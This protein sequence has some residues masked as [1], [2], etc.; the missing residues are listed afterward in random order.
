MSIKSFFQRTFLF[1]VLIILF[2]STYAW[3]TSQQESVHPLSGRPYSGTMSV[4]GAAWLDRAEREEEERPDKA[5][6][7]IGVPSG[8]VVA[9]IGAGSGY[10]TLRLSNLVGPTGHVYAVDIQ[11]GMLRIIQRKLERNQ[12]SNVSLVLGSQES[13][14]LAEASL[15]L[16]L[17]VDVYHELAQP[18]MLL[19]QLYLA[20]KPGGRLALLEYRAEDPAIPILPLH[21]MT[22]ADA[23]L[24]VEHEGFELTTVKS[25]DLPWQ[26]VLIFTKP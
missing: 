8:A 1:S 11:E 21:K 10:F 19:Q 18:Q 15:D 4:A 13:S 12:I 22:V 6:E 7:I 14:G 23:K 2:F 3:A 26:H 24:E 9:D 17:M 5:L 20:L 16:A 25:H